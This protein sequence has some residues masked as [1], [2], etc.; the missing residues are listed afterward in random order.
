LDWHHVD[1]TPQQPTNKVE[2]IKHGKIRLPK[3]ETRLISMP[4][5]SPNKRDTIGHPSQQPHGEATINGYPNCSQLRD[6]APKEEE[7]AT[8]SP[9]PD[10]E[11]LRSLERPREK[12]EHNPKKMPSRT[13]VMSMGII[14]VGSEKGH[15]WDFSWKSQ[16]LML[17]VWADYKQQDSL[18][19]DHKQGQVWPP[20]SL[21]E[22]PARPS[23][24]QL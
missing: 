18:H 23:D 7:D 6:D 10:Q 15:D 20:T 13:L 21:A 16:H 17:P 12:K 8:T 3:L 11:D 4:S 2:R 5:P 14:V 9:S 19:A 22:S 1:L 24:L